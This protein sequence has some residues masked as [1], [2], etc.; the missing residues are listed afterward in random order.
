MK[1]N[2]GALT[3]SLVPHTPEGKPQDISGVDCLLWAVGRDSN[4]VDLGLKSTG[5]ELNKKG[6]IN[7]DDFQNTNVSNIYA[8]GDIAGN[9]LLTPGTSCVTTIILPTTLTTFT[10]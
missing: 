8:L 5:V 10:D 2:E 3:V 6:F 9:K 7:V 1:K 4:M